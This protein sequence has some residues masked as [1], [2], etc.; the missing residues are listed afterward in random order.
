ML[1][2]VSKPLAL[3]SRLV[4][5][6]LA[7]LVAALAWPA[8]GAASAG[9]VPRRSAEEVQRLRLA[10][11]DGHH[12]SADVDLRIDRNGKTEDRGLQVWRDDSGGAGERL[13]ARFVAPSDL[14]GFGLLFLEQSGRPNDYFV[15]QPS[16]RRVRRVSESVVSQDIY[17]V[18]LE[19]LGFGIAQSVPTAAEHVEVVELDGRPVYRLEERAL[20]GNQRFDERVSWI[21][22]ETGVTLRTEHR[23]G[24]RP[25]LVAEVERL[26]DVQGV[27]TPMRSV[28]HRPGAEERVAMEVTRI[29][30]EQPIPGEFFSTLS[31][32]RR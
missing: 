11:L 9:A 21:D 1:E 28:F 30:Y 8:A 12:F 6:Q 18:D 4:A 15:H 3:R 20:E 17:G 29:D 19:F 13:L 23:R 16:L 7:A 25:T 14:R 10:R 32:I 22:P 24:G 26:A 5:F 31:L 27:P 2:A